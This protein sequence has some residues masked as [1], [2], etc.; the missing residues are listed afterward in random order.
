MATRARVSPAHNLPLVEEP[1]R[2]IRLPDGRSLAL[3]DVGDPSGTPVIYL[4]GTPDSRLSRHPDDGVAARSGVRLL[5]LDRPGAGHSDPNPCAKLGDLADDLRALLDE[6][7][8][9]RAALLGWSAGGL[10]AL[11]VAAS[12]DTRVSGVVLVGTVPPVEAYRDDRV[13]AALGP[14]RR[15]LAELALEVQPAELARELA[16]YLV[17]Y[18]VP[19]PLARQVTLDHVLE[20]AGDHGRAELAAVPGALGR[21]ADAL[22][23]SVAHGIEAL[24]ADL[25]RQLEPGLDLEAI[26]R[27]VRTIH[28]SEDEVSPPE[29][30]RWLVEHLPDARADV[31]PGAGHHLLFPRWAEVLR[32]AAGG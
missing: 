6:L 21:L 18:L 19:G 1:T 24:V 26:A 14:G 9:E 32:W 31:L 27:P 23:A 22:E 13:V 25:T 11:A 8:I 15:N 10:A 12:L 28:G 20:G 17:P 29:V 16:P 5:A 4:H 7:G 3:D 30:G 2:T